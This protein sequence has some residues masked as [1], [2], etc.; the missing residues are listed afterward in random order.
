M[1]A[2]KKGDLFSLQAPIQQLLLITSPTWKWSRSQEPDTVARILP[3]KR[4][5]QAPPVNP[6]RHHSDKSAT[7][8]NL[9]R[10]GFESLT[11]RLRPREMLA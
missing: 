11:T 7:L 9:N 4:R 8:L 1:T 6:L 10:P 2:S 3:L 5:N